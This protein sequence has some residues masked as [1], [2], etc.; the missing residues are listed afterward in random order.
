[1]TRRRRARA[2]RDRPETRLPNHVQYIPEA[3]G[4]D[5]L[6]I[7]N[8]VDFTITK[9]DR[10]PRG[11]NCQPITPERSTI[12]SYGRDILAIFIFAAEVCVYLGDAARERTARAFAER[13]LIDRERGGWRHELDPQNRPAA[14][15]WQ[16]KPDVYHALQATLIPRL[17]LAP[18]LAASLR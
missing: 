7:A 5:D 13:H 17:P 12:V 15:T 18:S 9:E 3:I 14:R 2:R 16:G 4:L 8:F 11:R 6:A 1:M 10:P